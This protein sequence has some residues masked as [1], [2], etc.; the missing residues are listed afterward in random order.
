VSL[1]IWQHPWATL[2]LALAILVLLI[3]TVRLIWR[4]LVKVFSGHWMP[5]RGLLQNARCSAAHPPSRLP[6]EE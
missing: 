4:A 6:P 1:L 3:L 5:G 2:A